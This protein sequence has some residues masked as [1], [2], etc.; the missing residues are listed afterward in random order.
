MIGSTPF[1]IRNFFICRGGG[2]ERVL[3]D[4]GRHCG[5]LESEKAYCVNTKTTDVAK[6]LFQT[7]F[8]QFRKEGIVVKR[9]R[10]LR[11]ASELIEISTKL[12]LS[13]SY[14]DVTALFLNFC[15]ISYV[16]RSPL[17]LKLSVECSGIPFDRC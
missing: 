10:P 11:I 4:Q 9:F 7:I 3:E 1:F 12:P 2:T 17:H 8:R 16:T 13:A 14:K 15:V 5:I 6:L